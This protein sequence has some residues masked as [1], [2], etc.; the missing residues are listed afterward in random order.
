MHQSINVLQ[1][2]L[3]VGIGGPLSL[4]SFPILSHRVQVMLVMLQDAFFCV[5]DNSPYFGHHHFVI[6]VTERA[7]VN[8]FLFVPEIFVVFFH[9][10]RPSRI[11]HQP[12]H[13][14][15]PS[16]E[17]PLAFR[18][19]TDTTNHSTLLGTNHV[20]TGRAV[21]HQKFMHL[22]DHLRVVRNLLSTFFFILF[23]FYCFFFAFDQLS[24]APH[25]SLHPSTMPSQS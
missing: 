15:V 2:C 10:S 18:E 6:L 4:P 17:L 23:I 19:Q 22:G 1:A 9:V 3:A 14:W 11:S 7:Q 20:S 24:V 8:S 25:L 5:L 13:L 12:L 21:A 16:V